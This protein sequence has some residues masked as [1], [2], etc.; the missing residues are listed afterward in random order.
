M[1]TIGLRSKEKVSP[2]KKFLK[3]NII[4][5]YIH[6]RIGTDLSNLVQYNYTCPP[7]NIIVPL[8]SHQKKIMDL[9]SKNKI[10]QQQNH[11]W[12]S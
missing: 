12:Q 10:T 4:Y 5:I 3:R 6:I 9:K 7:N 1:P 8:K 2:P 11:K